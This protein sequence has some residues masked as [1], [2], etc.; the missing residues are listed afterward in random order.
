MK[1]E[2]SKQFNLPAYINTPLF[3]YQDDRLDKAATM[4]A[5][6][7]Y[8]LHSSGKNITAST[9]YFSA[10]ANV[11]NRHIYRLL[12]KLEDCKYIRRSGS[13]NKRIIQWIYFPSNSIVI[14]DDKLNNLQ[15]IRSLN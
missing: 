8:S 7:I 9:D 5:S 1:N 2:N 3:L 10:L 13:T 4:L 15:L 12:D 14:T 6:F 11:T